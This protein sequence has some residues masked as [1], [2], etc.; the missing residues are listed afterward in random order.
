[1]LGEKVARAAV[2]SHLPIL[3]YIYPC[4]CL[5]HLPPLILL[6]TPSFCHVL[7]YSFDISDFTLAWFTSYLTD[8]TQTISVNGSKSLPAPLH[9]GVPKG[10]V[11]RPI[12]LSRI[13]YC[14]SL[15]AG[16]PKQLIHKL[17]KVRNNAA[18]FI[19]STSTSDHISPVL[20]ILHSL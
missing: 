15:L 6:T 12:L 2:S 19:C 4:L 18:R 3:S 7:C 1:M 13:D 11:L 9:Y 10:S 17:Q 20:H 8:R 5:I 16:C 14:N